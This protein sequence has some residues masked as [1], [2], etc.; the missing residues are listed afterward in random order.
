M[1]SFWQAGF[2][3]ILLPR[4]TFHMQYVC[5][6]FQLQVVESLRFATWS[7][8]NQIALQSTMI[9]KKNRLVSQTPK[10]DRSFGSKG[11]GDEAKWKGSFPMPN[12]FLQTHRRVFDFCISL[13][14]IHDKLRQ[15]SFV[16]LVVVIHN[17]QK[18]GPSF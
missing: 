14:G 15:S 6:R 5:A 16:S 13:V 4:V 18:Q 1:A 12:I 8:Q 2:A 10:T 17:C 9:I 3:L 7:W 11:K